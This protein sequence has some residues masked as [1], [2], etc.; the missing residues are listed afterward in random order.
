MSTIRMRVIRTRVGLSRRS[1]NSGAIMSCVI[2]VLQ[3]SRYPSCVDMNAA[4]IAAVSKPIIT[5][6]RMRPRK[7]G[8]A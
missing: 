8:I 1:L 4:I 3:Q 7:I 5:V 6:G 2:T